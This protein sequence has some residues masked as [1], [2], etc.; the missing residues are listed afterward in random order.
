MLEHAGTLTVSSEAEALLAAVAHAGTIVLTD[1]EPKLSGCNNLETEK[2]FKMRGISYM[3][4]TPPDLVIP[5]GVHVSYTEKRTVSMPEFIG[6]DEN[7]LPVTTLL[8]RAEIS[9]GSSATLSL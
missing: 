6:V 4:V 9:F 8:S 3:L 5:S 2:G 7:G 1:N